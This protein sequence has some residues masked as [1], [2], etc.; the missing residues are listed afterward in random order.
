MLAVVYFVKYFRHYLH[1]KQFVVRTDH[2]SLMWL[3]NF[4]N[5]EGQIAR[6][7]EVLSS[8][9]LK[10]EHRQGR[11]HGNAD[12]LSRIPCKQCGMTDADKNNITENENSVHLGTDEKDD[13]KS[14]QA[15][16]KDLQ[17]VIEWVQKNKK[18]TFSV[19]T[20]EHFTVKCLWNQIKKLRYTTELF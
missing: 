3:L 4:K 5:P 19:I 13:I 10:I 1:G 15:D 17:R 2:G 11:S 14:L 16:D 9:P 20:E 8:Y 18:P 7:I 6:W 12:G